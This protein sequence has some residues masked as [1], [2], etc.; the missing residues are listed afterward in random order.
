M[1]YSLEAV[2]RR[3]LLAIVVGLA[4][5]VLTPFSAQATGT[6]DVSTWRTVD[7]ALVDFQDFPSFRVIRSVFE[8]RGHEHGEKA[9][10]FI[11]WREGNFSTRKPAMCGGLRYA[12]RYVVDTRAHA[13]QGWFG[14]ANGE[15]RVHLT[16]TRRLSIFKEN[17]RIGPP[18]CIET[19]G[20]WSSVWSGVPGSGLPGFVSFRGTFLFNHDDTLTFRGL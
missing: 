13:G 5:A 17:T 6:Q 9:Y 18:I 3:W 1:P 10:L 14:L 16:I 8:L 19:E 12:G 2:S 15:G 20:T 4:S 11:Q 7:G